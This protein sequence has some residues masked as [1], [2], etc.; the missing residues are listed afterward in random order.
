MSTAEST[1]PACKQARP[2][3]YVAC[4]KCWNRLPFGLRRDFTKGN[5]EVRRG[6]LREVLHR[7]HSLESIAQP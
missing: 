2:P 7:L 6:L 3:R 1:C 4:W 5:P